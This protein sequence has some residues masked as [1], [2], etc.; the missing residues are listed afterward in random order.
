M[1]ATHVLIS[2]ATSLL[3]AG[4]VL[5][6]WDG[7]QN[8]SGFAAAGILTAQTSILSGFP[9]GIHLTL[10][11]LGGFFLILL[12]LAGT[13]AA[14]FGVG[15]GENAGTRGHGLLLDLG[16]LLFIAFM[17]AVFLAANVFTFLFAWEGMAASSF[18]LVVRDFSDREAVRAGLVY[19]AMTQ[20]GTAFL[21]VAFLSL[22][23]AI[24]SYEFSAFARRA[25]QIPA[26]L[27]GIVFLS[28]LI[29][30]SVKAGLAPVHIWLPL[31]HPAAPSHV[32]A[33]MSGVMVK[34]AL[35]GFLLIDVVWMRGGPLW[36]GAATAALG[37]LSAVSGAA[38][39]GQEVHLKRVLA[40]ST[41]ENMGILF[42]SVGA[43][44]MDFSL[45]RFL[46]GDFTLAATLYHAL[47]HTLFKGAL[48]QGAGS[49]LHAAGTG[50]L[51]RLGG[52]VRRMPWTSIT[53]LAAL[54]SSAGIPPFGGFMS[55]WMLFTSLAHALSPPHRHLSGLIAAGSV[56]ALLV[57]GALGVTVAAR[58]FSVGFLAEPRSDSA[59]CATEGP[60]TLRI[61]GGF[62]MAA[63]LLA[64]AFPAWVIRQIQRALPQGAAPPPRGL[65]Q[66]SFP[67]LERL[68]PALSLSLFSSVALVWILTRLTGAKVRT[69]REPTWTCGGQ[70]VPSMS[71][72]ATGFSQPIHRTFLWAMKPWAAK[73]FYRP[74]LRTVL[75]TATAFRR[76]QNGHV[77]SYLLYLFVTVLALLV[78][79]RW[80]G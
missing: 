23:T 74:L 46:L 70:R 73:G 61:A 67:F 19:A 78:A 68:S 5:L 20:V 38:R 34:T 40:Y 16:V 63:V 3:C 27:Q 10:T 9:A 7:L 22:H 42:L 35:Y 49:V 69:V 4:I 79:A 58:L 24:G 28:A 1:R 57:T 41:I 65:L 31:A 66:T 62:S 36:W 75:K 52:L 12:G 54:L 2:V 43:A 37:A 18:L 48:F 32:S 72:S 44:M 71:Y 17:A 59:A 6:G 26:V 56:F 55:E 30:F 50:S 11:P 45:H 13:P 51:N 60:L 29:G 77:R 80:G 8:G 47:N 15:Y 39:A 33:L 53:V 14:V 21:F 25:D 76:I 64:G